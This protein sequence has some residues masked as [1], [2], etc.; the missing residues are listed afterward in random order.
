MEV[1]AYELIPAK[2]IDTKAMTRWLKP[3]RFDRRGLETGPGSLQCSVLHVIAPKCY[4]SL[5]V[6]EKKN[7]H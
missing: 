7:N 2:N 6:T 1:R 4:V 3:T 5:V